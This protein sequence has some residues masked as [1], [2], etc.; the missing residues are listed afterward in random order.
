[1]RRNL[2]FVLLAFAG[3]L[4][5][6]SCKKTESTP[7]VSP[8]VYYPLKT[9]TSVTYR[10]D[11]TLPVPFGSSLYDVYHDMKDSIVSTFND[12]AGRLSYLVYRYITDTFQSQP[13]Q[14]L[15]TYFITPTSTDI[16]VVDDNNYRFIKLINPVVEGNSWM[17]NSYILTDQEYSNVSYLQ[18]WDYTY[19]NVNAPDSV[20]MG[21]I[22]NTVT[23]LQTD[24]TFPQGEV[25]NDTDV[26]YERDYGIEVYAKNIGLISKDFL[27]LNWGTQ[28]P[29]EPYS[30]SDNSYSFKISMISYNQ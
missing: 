17:G 15:S 9:G 11:S 1:M 27:H 8:T 18:G 29:G 19:E 4:Y 2:L 5:F 20:M 22:G 7:F 13:W 6:F 25:F 23:V 30:Y 26:Y 16:E 28:T 3:F 24:Q 21:V 12:D 10:L 14:Y